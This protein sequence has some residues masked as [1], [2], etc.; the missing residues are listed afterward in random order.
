M[1]R[2]LYMHLPLYLDLKSAFVR[3]PIWIHCWAFLKSLLFCIH[4]VIVCAVN[5]V[6]DWRRFIWLCNCFKLYFYLII[7]FRFSFSIICCVFFISVA[8]RFDLP[9]RLPESD[10][11]GR[12][13]WIAFDELNFGITYL[14]HFYCNVTQ[15]LFVTFGFLIWQ[16]V[17]CLQHRTAVEI[18][19]PALFAVF[20]SN[21]N[22]IVLYPDCN[23]W[24]PVMSLLVLS[25][26]C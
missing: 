12:I 20:F 6:F 18:K 21:T 17:F 14:W 8:W 13:L 2:T 23:F 1:Y 4:L 22:D 26:G 15:S 7:E 24:L 3:K 10:S 9:V 16:L 5:C 11:G 19:N 25:F